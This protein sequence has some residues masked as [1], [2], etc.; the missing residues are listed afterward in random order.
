MAG[1]DDA[2]LDVQ[3]GA[4]LGA[5][6]S[7]MASLLG[8]VVSV[9]LIAGLA[10]W[11]YRLAVRDVTG[12]PVIRALEGPMRVAPEDPGGQTASYQGLAVNRVAAEGEAAPPPDRL[13]L[14][15]R[16]TALAEEDMT[17]AGLTAPPPEPP[18]APPEEAAAAEDAVEAGA[19]EQAV[20][21]ALAA[22]AAQMAEAA[23]IGAPARIS[24]DL[25][26]MPRPARVARAAAQAA[27]ATLTPAAATAAPAAPEEIDPSRLKA[28]ARLVQLGAFDDAE[29]ARKEWQRLSAR[30][31]TYL[32]GKSRVIQ[33]AQSGGRSFYRLRA[34]GFA[35]DAD[36]RRFC[37]A[38]LAEQAACIP[39]PVR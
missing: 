26:P 16:P 20:E 3:A 18:A 17:V 4:G 8:A 29:T 1:F 12:V 15:P 5:R 27:P 23:P 31:G 7:R 11:G 35:D 6:V 37:A 2:D 10:I 9:A 25:R 14:A 33:Q 36:A 21:Q 19:V 24:P 34:A 30:F 28:D 22:P 32:A 38:L 13:V 39:V